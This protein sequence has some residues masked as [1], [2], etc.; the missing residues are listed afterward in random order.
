MPL[1]DFKCLRCGKEFEGFSKMT[2][3][4][5]VQCGCGGLT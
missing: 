3:R 1:Y 2:D 5:N 4:L